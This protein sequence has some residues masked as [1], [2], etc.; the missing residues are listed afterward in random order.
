VS[1]TEERRRSLIA[2]V[3]DGNAVDWE[4]LAAGAVDED[5]RRWLRQLKAVARIAKAHRVADD[6]RAR[7]GDEPAEEAIPGGQTLSHFRVLGELGQGGM[8][9]VYRA[10]DQDLHRE[11]ALKLL[12]G[13]LAEDPEFRSRLLRE[14]RTAAALAHPNICTVFEVG[15]TSEQMQIDT[16]GRPVSLPPGTPFIAMELMRGR[17][18]RQ[19]VRE[20]GPLEP[21]TLLEIAIQIAQGLAAAHRQGI[22]HRDLKPANVMVTD[23]GPVKILDFGLARPTITTES[24]TSARPD[25][26]GIDWDLTRT[27]K[28]LG[29]VA[30]MS[31]E[32]AQGRR[33]DTRS[34]V[35]SFGAM[36]YE[37]CTGRRPSRILRD[38]PERLDACRTDLPPRLADVIHRC[39]AKEPE[40]RYAEA[41]EIAEELKALAGSPGSDTVRAATGKRRIAWILGLVLV[42]AVPLGMWLSRQVAEGPSTRAEAFVDEFDR[43][44][45]PGS[46]DDY[47]V[48][49]FD[50]LLWNPKVREGFLTLWTHQGDT[51]NENKAGM[52]VRNVVAREYG[53][54]R[55]EATVR[56][57]DFWPT[58]N[59]QQAGLLVFADQDNYVRLT[60]VSTF[61]R[62]LD[63][64]QDVHRIQAVLER[65]DEVLEAR[66]LDLYAN[67]LDD[68]QPL[69]YK[70]S[71]DGPIDEI[72]LRITRDGDRWTF[73]YSPNGVT[74]LR[75]HT[76]EL[77]IS[78]PL[79]TR[80]IGLAAFHG[81]GEGKTRNL[82][83][84]PIPAH[85]DSFEI[86]P[87]T[88]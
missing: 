54:K 35:F 53:T 20:S 18:L 6:A 60:L 2:S 9:V 61:M 21:G 86:T 4:Q 59:W 23:E 49:H 14:A 24:T 25:I 15:R 42:C 22:V 5:E 44:P 31:P 7:R 43:V 58:R 1:A 12:P 64:P 3:S 88:D 29:T 82:T 28:V 30:Y 72:W 80:Y 66:T 69:E 83:W 19:I 33:V 8:G 79:E 16:D 87:I 10:L 73:R 62:G 39:L 40:H 56:L 38:E 34:D 74:F 84:D 76:K 85:F 81:I 65:D 46:S 13:D 48:F 11:V 55:F 51:W 32:Q 37:L 45:D 63:P 47:L 27:G 17:T 77:F 57:Q 52:K 26:Q 71:H 75:I 78:F 36:L 67:R 50:E 68:V 70:N 41:G